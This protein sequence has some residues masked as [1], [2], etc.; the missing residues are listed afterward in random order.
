DNSN[1]RAI[2]IPVKTTNGPNEL[3]CEAA[4]GTGSYIIGD[5]PNANLGEVEPINGV[6]IDFV[7]DASLTSLRV[8]DRDATDGNAEIR[9]PADWANAISVDLYVR[10]LGK[11]GGCIGA[12]AFV[13]DGSTYYYAGTAVFK[14]KTG[15]SS[16]VDAS[17]LTD[18]W[19]CPDGATVS[20]TTGHN[21]DCV[22]TDGITVVAAEEF[23]V[24]NAV[25]SEYFWDVNNDGVRV[26]Q[27][28]MRANF[29]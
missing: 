11:P 23:N 14:R 8:S 21:Y 18:V 6:R 22:A 19:Y 5:L 15:Q 3:Y 25:F 17:E 16:F 10:V 2:F 1:G 24:F 9:V 27:V 29:F 12:D 13:F 7:K 20:P 26:T 28:L 4:D